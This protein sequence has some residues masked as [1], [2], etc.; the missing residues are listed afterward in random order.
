[1]AP[2]TQL[3]WNVILWKIRLFTVTITKSYRITSENVE[4]LRKK[5][6]SISHL[7]E[8]QIQ[9]KAGKSGQKFQLYS[10]VIVIILRQQ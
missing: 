6:A 10:N 8:R 3:L 2:N 4:Y 7:V 5:S 1:M 9:E